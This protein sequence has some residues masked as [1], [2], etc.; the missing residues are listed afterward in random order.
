MAGVGGRL[1]DAE[2]DIA[3]IRAVTD[4]LDED[5]MATLEALA[6]LDADTLA[7]LAAL[8]DD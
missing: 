3:D 5:T 4:K 8:D 6:K 1:D 2:G 7:E